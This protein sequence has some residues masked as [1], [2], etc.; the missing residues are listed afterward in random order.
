MRQANAVGAENV[1]GVDRLIAVFLPS[2]A[3]WDS[4]LSL[5]AI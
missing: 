3:D 5:H 4:E 1:K 2:V